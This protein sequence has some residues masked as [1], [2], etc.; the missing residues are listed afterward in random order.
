MVF[1]QVGADVDHPDEVV[2]VGSVDRDRDPVPEAERRAPVRVL[3]AQLAGER[4]RHSRDGSQLLGE[5]LALLE[6]DLAA[7]D[8]GPEGL[9]VVRQAASH[10]LPLAGDHRRSVAG[11][12]GPGPSRRRA[13]ASAWRG[14]GYGGAGPESPAR[15]DGRNPVEQACGW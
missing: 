1:S 8:A 12:R 11:S 2:E 10:A 5:G 6:P 15:R 14:A 7:R 3:A 4:L 9:L 13:R